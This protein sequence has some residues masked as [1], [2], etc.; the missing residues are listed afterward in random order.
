MSPRLSRLFA[1]LCLSLGALLPATAQGRGGGGAPG[2][3]LFSGPNFTG[4]S[5]Y[6][7]QEE[8]NLADRGFNDRAMSV[9]L[10]GRNQSWQLCDA[11]GFAGPCVFINRDEP[12]L[13]RIGLAGRVSS[14]RPTQVA[15]GPG[16]GGPGYGGPGYGG[17]GGGVRPPAD[18]LVLFEGEFFRGRRISLNE[19][20]ANFAW[21]QFNDAA[22]SLVA[23]GRWLVCERA[24]F[25]GTCREVEGE[26]RDLRE[27]GLSAAISS[28]RPI[29]YGPSGPGYY[30]PGYGGFG[31]VDRPD[32]SGRTSAFF[33]FPR[34]DGQPVLINR[35]GAQATADAFCQAGGFRQA[36]YFALSN[37]RGGQ[38]LE[39][40]LCIR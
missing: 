14:F 3:E 22:R 30:D 31:R 9:R 12:D 8:W 13:G 16:Y 26:V 39:E 11:H 17:P 23:D 27:I 25:T 29:G 36:R 4:D 7:P 5:R 19:S 32:S 6:F 40:V 33:A 20:T 35:Q 24:D 15:G 34:A 38:V 2:I 21:V 28:A 18:G 1:A 10:Y 37:G